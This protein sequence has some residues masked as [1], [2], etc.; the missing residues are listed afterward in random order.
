MWFTNKNLIELFVRTQL[1]LVSNAD[2]KNR[3]PFINRDSARTESTIAEPLRPDDEIVLS[4][5]MCDCLCSPQPNV[6]LLNA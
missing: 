2:L 6:G 1:R 3:L 4:I 5:R